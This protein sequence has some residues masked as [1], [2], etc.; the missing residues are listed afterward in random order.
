[1]TKKRRIKM[2]TFFMFGTYT[3]DAVKKISITRTEQAIDTIDKLGGEVKGIYALL[4]EYDLLFCVNLPNVEAATKASISLAQ[5][6]GI[7][8]RTCPAIKV[9]VFDRLVTE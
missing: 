5:L 2:A 3:P 9:E 6:T 8:F 1:M 4:G 7:T